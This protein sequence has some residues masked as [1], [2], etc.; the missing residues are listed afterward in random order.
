[1]A[2][3]EATFEILTGGGQQRTSAAVSAKTIVQ[4][5]VSPGG[6][7]AKL[8]KFSDLSA[9]TATLDTGPL[10]EAC[11][12]RHR[13]GLT[14]YAVPTKP[15]QAGAVGTVTQKGTGTGTVTVGTAPHKA[16]K[17]KITNA[18]AI[19]TMKFRVSYDGGTTYQPEVTS[20]D[21]GGGSF[22]YRVP[23]TFCTLTFA[24]GTYV[25]NSTYDIGV[26]GTVTIGGGGINTVTQASDPID[27]YDVV[28]KVAKG[29]ALGVAI[30][31]VSLDGEKSTLPDMLIPS[32]GKVV[33]SGTGLVLTCANTFVVDETYSFLAAPPGFSTTDLQNA[34]VALRGDASA[35]PVALVHVIGL[36][37]SAAN[38]FSA[39][40]TLDTQI[41]T[42]FS[43]NNFDWQGLAE[44]PYKDD[45]I[46]SGGAAIADTAD[47]DA[48][49]TSARVGSTF[50]R[51]AICVG[52]HRMTSPITGHKLKRPLGWALAARYADT[53][54]RQDVS[55]VA[56][57][58]LPIVAIG[59]DERTAA[60]TLHD[61][62]LN[63][64]RSYIGRSGAFLAIESGGFGWRNLT[65]DASY[66]DAGGVRVLDVAVAALRVA[67]QRYLGD[68]P[69]TNPDGT[70]EEK[71]ARARETDLD[72][73]IKRATGLLRGGDFDAPQ[74][75]IA[76]ATVLRTS[77]LGQSPRRLDVQY[78]LQPLGF[79][80]SVAGKVRFSGVI[81][82]EA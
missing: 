74:A 62:Q 13:T 17:I 60:T 37:S 69:A 75:S 45:T 8:Y 38:A 20:A 52:T 9:I 12:L 2:L 65:T 33:V 40:S 28:V 71:A 31:R 21:S 54:P 11:A 19:A 32:G 25:L 36:P 23:G 64:A 51:V 4:L 26:D 72:G 73:A 30:L 63:V 5:G 82:L 61:V 42:A 41:D 10:A 77:Q 79:V 1:M 58:A 80:S 35:P 29:G 59:R 70:I 46:V 76:S 7:E 15:S 44:C 47:T 14:T 67:G 22:V 24:A 66:Q 34:M 49:I 3:G 68:R 48:A 6:D 39:G 43:T 81:S 16:I 57:G 56:G 55:A 53:E 50:D 18:G 78:T 27:N